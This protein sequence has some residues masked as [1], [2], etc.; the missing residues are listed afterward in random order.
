MA[1]GPGKKHQKLFSY[2][3]SHLQKLIPYA[4]RFN[5]FTL[6]E[7]NGQSPPYTFPIGVGEDQLGLFLTDSEIKKH[8]L[9]D[10]PYIM[11]YTAG[12]V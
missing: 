12:M 2:H 7:Y 11:S 9:I 6:S 1:P 4:N 5:T 3:L 8:D 10:Q